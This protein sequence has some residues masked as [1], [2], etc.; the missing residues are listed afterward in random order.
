MQIL[1][2]ENEIN[3]RETLSGVIQEWWM[4]SVQIMWTN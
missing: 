2:D 1:I 4:D 3:L